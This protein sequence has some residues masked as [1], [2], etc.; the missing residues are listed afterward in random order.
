MKEPRALRSDARLVVF[1]IWA[2]S[3]YFGAACGI[4]RHR[5]LKGGFERGILKKECGKTKGRFEKAAL[6]CC[7]T[8][9]TGKFGRSAQLGGKEEEK[10]KEQEKRTFC[11]R[12]PFHASHTPSMLHNV[13]HSVDIR[14]PLYWKLRTDP[15]GR[16]G[17]GTDNDGTQATAEGLRSVCGGVAL[18]G[19]AQMVMVKGRPTRPTPAPTRGPDEQQINHILNEL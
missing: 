14:G 16:L 11:P 7:A 2:G 9:H 10:V 3:T 15:T 18:A 1:R 6:R 17:I 4:A 5:H 19:A 8:P 12:I 13:R